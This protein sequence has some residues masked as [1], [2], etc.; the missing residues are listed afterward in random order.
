MEEALPE[1][2]T[3][4]IL[5]PTLLMVKL[6]EMDFIFIQTDLIILVSSRTELSMEKE[7]SFINLT[8]WLMKENGRME[9]Q[10]EKVLKFSQES[11]SMKVILR[12]D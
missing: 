7:N 4:H 6:K 10:M 9:S 12:T 11:E 1:D 8:E 5:M 3:E 2:Q